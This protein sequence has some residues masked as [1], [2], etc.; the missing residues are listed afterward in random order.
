MIVLL[1]LAFGMA[2]DGLFGW[3]N[4]RFPPADDDHRGTRRAYVFVSVLGAFLALL[5]LPQLLFSRAS[6]DCD[7]PIGASIFVVV[8]GIGTLVLWAAWVGRGTQRTVSI[9][10]AIGFT[11]LV[12]TCVFG[13]WRAASDALEIL[14]AT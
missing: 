14:N 12:G 7:P 10:H 11:G 5:A 13:L 4:R 3:F 2:M 8:T 6:C 9:A 1:F